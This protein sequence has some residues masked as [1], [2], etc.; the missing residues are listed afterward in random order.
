MLKVSVSFI[1]TLYYA[2]KNVDLA[3]YVVVFNL[4]HLP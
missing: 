2:R 4:C 1:V 3:L